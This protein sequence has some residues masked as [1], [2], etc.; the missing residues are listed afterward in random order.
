MQVIELME[1]REHLT[2]EGL[3][4]ILAI[5]ASM[6]HGLSPKLKLAFPDIVPQIVV[7]PLVENQKVH[8][9]NWLAGFT[10]GEGS[11]IVNIKASKTHSIG[12]QVF[13]V[14]E[15]TQHMRDE[16]LMRSLIELLQCG[17]IYKN[18]NTFDFRVSKFADITEKIIPLF[19]KYPIL[20]VKAIDF[21][22]W[23]KA[24]ELM[25][26]KKHLTLEGLEEIKKIKAG[27]NTDRKN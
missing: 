11:F 8:D 2:I 26:Q 7:R 13:L 23:C 22:D 9:P 5:R 25:K 15:L 16:Q 19:L 10:T 6:N 17:N 14:F 20:C 27:M 24:A 18:R 12:F 4:K 1:R 3:H 21:E